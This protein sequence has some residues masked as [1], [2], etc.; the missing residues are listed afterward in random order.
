[1]PEDKLEIGHYVRT[2]EKAGSPR[3]EG[4]ILRIEGSLAWIDVR[5]IGDA[6]VDLYHPVY[7]A[8]ALQLLER[9]EL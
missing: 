1:M 2:S 5:R 9:G 8:R 7:R 6:R 4:Y 3:L